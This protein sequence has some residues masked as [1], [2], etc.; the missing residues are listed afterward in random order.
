M[1]STQTPSSSLALLSEHDQFLAKAT[2]EALRDGIQLERWARD[3][4]RTIK[5]FPL[6]LYRPFKKPFT[7]KNEAFGYF[8]DVEINGKTLPAVGLLQRIDFS[9]I[10]PEN[11]EQKL[12]DFVLGEFMP[13][14][15][16]TYDDGFPGGFTIQ[17]M[18]YRS[19]SGE[20]GT[21]PP[22][23]RGGCVDWRE[24]GT[25]YDWVL[26]TIRL[27]DFVV[28]IGPWL[29]RLDEAV[30]VVL[31]R[32]FLH[33]TEKPAPGYKLDIS[34]GYPFIAFAPIPN[35]FGFGPGKFDWAIKLFSFLLTDQNEV[36]MTMDFVAGRRP[37]KVFYFGKLIPD[38][39]YGGAA[40]LNLLTLGLWSK[41]KF[42]DK[43]DGEMM[44][45]HGRVHQ[46]LADG[47]AKI[48]EE[49]VQK[50]CPPPEAP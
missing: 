49:W 31:H 10:C 19:V 43:M 9:K 25:K 3:P 21:T 48:W 35:F 29:K 47:V 14:A 44:R 30:A 15:H 36:V 46:S 18:L 22:T 26:I 11:P 27:Y 23:A 17:P 12:L 1:V 5:Q 37:S 7:L 33:I 50:G 24:L 8:A 45:Q 4:K 16:W 40:L 42:H 20:Y 2:E 41:A 39:V 28:N 13:R 32:D 34:I 6:L 38:P